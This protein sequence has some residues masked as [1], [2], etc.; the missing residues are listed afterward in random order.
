MKSSVSS[1][2]RARSDA[3]SVPYFER[4]FENT[5]LHHRR[6]AYPHPLNP[7]RRTVIERKIERGL[8]AEPAGKGGLSLVYMVRPH[9]DESWR[10]RP[11]IEIFVGA[12][13]G[14]VRLTMNWTPFVGPRVVEF[15]V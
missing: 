9:V 4:G 12:A 10:T 15:K 11:A 3:I 1:I 2:E 13:R 6:G 14:E 7:P 5:H 8:M